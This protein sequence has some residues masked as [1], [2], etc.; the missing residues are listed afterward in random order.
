[1]ALQETGGPLLMGLFEQ[2]NLLKILIILYNIQAMT[3]KFKCPWW[4]IKP[5]AS[6]IPGEH[7]NC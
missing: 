6:H 4:V 1:M 5:D 2:V 7:P 3:E